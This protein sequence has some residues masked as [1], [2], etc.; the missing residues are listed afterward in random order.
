MFEVCDKLAAFSEKLNQWQRRV[1]RGQL[2]HFQHLQYYLESEKLECTFRYLIT[3]HIEILKT[4]LKNYFDIDFEMFKIKQWVQ[5]PFDQSTVDC[6]DDDQFSLKEEYIS[7][8]ADSSLKVEFNQVPLA[9]FWIARL[10]EYSLLA[11]EA[12]KLL[13]SFPTSWECEAA[14]SKLSI[15]KTKNRNR[16]NV[17]PDHRVALS[18]T[19]PRIEHIIKNKIKQV[20]PS[21]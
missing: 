7:L 6:I 21:H 11:K 3:D 15:I 17:E 4:H 18:S 8:R 19:S 20:H 16:L 10:D 9:E 1:D 12:V 5:F 2:E 14:F 13:V